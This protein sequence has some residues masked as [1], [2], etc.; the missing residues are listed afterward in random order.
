MMLPRNLSLSV[1]RDQYKDEVKNMFCAYMFEMLIQ[2]QCSL[3]FNTFKCLF[4]DYHFENMR[5]I[6]SWQVRFTNFFLSGRTCL[7]VLRG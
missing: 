6:F 2:V 5:Y 3:N 1:S 7:K 4:S